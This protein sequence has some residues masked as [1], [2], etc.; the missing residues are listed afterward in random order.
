MPRTFAAI[1][2]P[3][4]QLLINV[5]YL[6]GLIRSECKHLKWPPL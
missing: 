1:F 3:F 5:E 2:N 4:Q 6:M